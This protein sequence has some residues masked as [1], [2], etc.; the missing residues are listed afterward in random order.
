MM[1]CHKFNFTLL[2]FSFTIFSYQGAPR[3][4]WTSGTGIELDSP[5]AVYKCPL[6]DSIANP[7]AEAICTEQVR[8]WRVFKHDHLAF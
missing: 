5:G 1:L 7:D 4:N 3:A 6:D 8:K 2:Y